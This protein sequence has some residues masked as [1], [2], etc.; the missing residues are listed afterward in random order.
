MGMRLPIDTDFGSAVP[1][2]SK[3]PPL[4]PTPMAQRPAEIVPSK[5]K[6]K[7][8]AG[9][10]TP[11]PAWRDREIE[12]PHFKSEKLFQ[13]A[14]V[15]LAKA[16]GFIVYHT[17][18]SRGSEAGHPD[19]HMLHPWRKLQVVAELKVG[20]NKCSPAQVAWLEAYRAC[21]VQAFEWRPAMWVEI[22]CVL[23]GVK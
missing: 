6:A 11:D 16:C 8:K 20:S 21:G 19:L 13:A 2:S 15:K 9:K 17:L 7:V 10:V 23:R 14:V 1:V 5:S 18:N 3:R 12:A 4:I 22:E